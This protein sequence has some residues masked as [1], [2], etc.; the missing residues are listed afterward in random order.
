VYVEPVSTARPEE[1][2]LLDGR[3]PFVACSVIKGPE[4]SLG[5]RLVVTGSSVTGTLGAALD[6]PVTRAA[7]QRLRDPKAGTEAI[8]GRTV[9]FDVL[10][11]PP[12]LVLF[13]AGDDAIPLAGFAADAGFRVVVADYRPGY[14]TRERFPKAAALRTTDA[15]EGL[16][17]VGLD[18]DSFAVVMTH[19]YAHDQ[20]YAAALLKTVVPYIGMLG[21]RARRER[22]VQSLDAAGAVLSD[23]A[24]RL[25]GPVGLDIG[26]DGAEQV[27]LSV[28][29]EVLAI[30]SGRAARSLRE[31]SAPIH[32]EA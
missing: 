24:D 6:R 10:E 1:R 25:Y 17:D 9:F 22:V 28:V 7:R 13:G 12:Q 18:D 19:N 11:P 31:R 26:T 3:R 20:A 30:R 27:A 16:G 2:A 15:S 8:E 21:P 14:L 29:A 4:A 32:S 23:Y 5:Q